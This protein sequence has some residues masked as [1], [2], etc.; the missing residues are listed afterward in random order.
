MD[1]DGADK[2]TD[3]LE[4]L[5]RRSQRFATAIAVIFGLVMANAAE[6]GAKKWGLGNSAIFIEVAVGLITAAVVHWLI[7]HEKS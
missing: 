4:R 2:V 6:I 5:E 3:Q 1:N 7:M